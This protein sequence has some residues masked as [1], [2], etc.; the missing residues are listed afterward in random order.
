MK[1]RFARLMLVVLCASLA[2]GVTLSQSVAAQQPPCMSGM[3]HGAGMPDCDCGEQEMMN[4]AQHCAA[5][6]AGA[7]LPVSPLSLQGLKPASEGVSS[8]SLV[9]F[10][11]HAGPPGLQPPK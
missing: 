7:M 4:C 9:D 3:D 6:F 1:S 5:L 2:F 11:S 8:S 10:Q